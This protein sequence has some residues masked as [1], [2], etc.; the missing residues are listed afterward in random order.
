MSKNK[1][2]F[3]GDYVLSGLPNAFNQKTMIYW[4]SKKEMT[5][6]MYCFTIPGADTLEYKL[7]CIDTYI[8]IFQEKYETQTIQVFVKEQYVRDAQMYLGQGIDDGFLCMGA[9][10]EQYW[11]DVEAPMFLHTF[12]GVSLD[13]AKKLMGEKY[14]DANL[15]IF[16]FVSF[17]GGIV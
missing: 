13:E 11:K 4:L 17:S 5:V 6:A 14:P 8:K 2:F 3:F 9:E 16:E 15:K 7:R 10:N 1:T 12:T